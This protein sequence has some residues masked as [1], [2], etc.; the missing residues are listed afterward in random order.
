MKLQ[1][2]ELQLSIEIGHDYL[3]EG[4]EEIIRED[5]PHDIWFRPCF[6][7]PQLPQD[8]GQNAQEGLS[9]VCP[10]NCWQSRKIVAPG[11]SMHIRVSGAENERHLQTSE[12]ML[13]II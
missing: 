7:H 12:N 11:R 2:F 1:R 8:L 3:G 9:P 10:C 5:G 13:T 6:P 4:N